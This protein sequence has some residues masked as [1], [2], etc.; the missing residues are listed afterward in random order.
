[1]SSYF[2]GKNLNNNKN[3]CQLSQGETFNIEKRKDIRSE[4]KKDKN[5]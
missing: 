5:Y 3:G 1:M 4:M 2:N